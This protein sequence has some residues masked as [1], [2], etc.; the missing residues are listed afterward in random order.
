V[1]GLP[2]LAADIG[3]YLDDV[4]LLGWLFLT[5]RLT[6]QPGVAALHPAVHHGHHHG[7]D[8][9]L[10]VLTALLLAPAVGTLA[11]RLRP[12]LAALLAL[13]FCYGVGNLAND[14]WLEQVVKRGWS[15]WQMPEVTVPHANGG[16]AVILL[17]ALAVWLVWRRFQGTRLPVRERRL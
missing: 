17:A 2:W 7:M 11:G 6:S 10:L 13:M 12:V 1:I 4:P 8:G 5:G 9:V 3:F 16:W 14:A 15:S